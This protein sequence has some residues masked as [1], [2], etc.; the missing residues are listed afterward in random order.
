MT[1]TRGRDQVI[2]YN[3]DLTDYHP[4]FPH[5][6]VLHR[7]TSDNWTYYHANHP[8]GHCYIQIKDPKLYPRPPYTPWDEEDH[9][10][11]VIR[12]TGAAPHQP[13]APVR[14][15]EYVLVIEFLDPELWWKLKGVGFLENFFV[16]G[17][18]I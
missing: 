17:K 14:E 13:A 10:R 2:V 3:T 9:V 18:Q 7:M 4:P 6:E 16:D 5:D 8:N 12:R 1:S 11:E 15:A